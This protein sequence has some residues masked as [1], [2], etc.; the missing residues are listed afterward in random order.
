MAL[1]LK[2]WGLLRI[3]ICSSTLI[4]VRLILFSSSSLQS[5]S[6]WLE[7]HGMWNRNPITFSGFFPLCSANREH[8]GDL[9][10]P[11][12]FLNAAANS[13]EEDDAPLPVEVVDDLRETSRPRR[14]MMIIG[15]ADVRFDK[16]R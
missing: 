16:A 3:G 14:T 6:Y 15:C 1:R 10:I 12:N 5:S 2:N 4:P 13:V 11:P 7:F 8:Y 9:V